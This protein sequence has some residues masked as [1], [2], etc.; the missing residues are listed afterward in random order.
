MARSSE[1]AGLVSNSE[2]MADVGLRIG[3]HNGP[4]GKYCLA[5]LGQALDQAS[6]AMQLFAGSPRRYWSSAR[7]P[8]EHSDEFRDK[9]AHL[10]KTVHS[11]YI[12]NA[13]DQPDTRNA[14][15]TLHSLV[16]QLKWAERHGCDS[17][18]FHPG[19]RKDN[20]RDDA[21]GWLIES[22]RNIMAEYDGP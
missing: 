18:V 22:C 3:S 21:I 9:G 7:I 13:C 10:Y 17:V 5:A 1:N 12:V 19:S 8:P 2:R 14:R 15:M 16:D 6:S 20:P 11:V 4:G